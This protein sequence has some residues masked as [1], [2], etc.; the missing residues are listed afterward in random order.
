MSLYAFVAT[1]TTADFVIP[2]TATSQG[3]FNR[4][5]ANAFRGLVGGVL[6]VG[7]IKFRSVQTAIDNHLLCDGTTITRAQFPELVTHLAGAAATEATLPDFSG[8]LTA[9]TPT[10]TQTTTDSGTV[11]TSETAPI[12]A[13]QTGGTTGGNVRSGG[14]LFPMEERVTE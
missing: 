11:Q 13:G 12:P 14:R 7:D 2:V 1:R 10:V 8:S 3:E 5:V 4:K 9:T 6:R